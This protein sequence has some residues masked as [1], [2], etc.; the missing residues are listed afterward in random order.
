MN[1]ASHEKQLRE[2][3]S[4]WQPSLQRLCAAYES[5]AAAQEKLLKRMLTG[6][7]RSLPREGDKCSL[8]SWVYRIAFNVAA[9]R[10][11]RLVHKE[12]PPIAGSP[13]GDSESRLA[14]LHSAIRRM[15]PLN[16]QIIL[17]HLEEVPP[18][19][20]AEITGLA[21][22]DI[23]TRQRQ[24]EGRLV[25]LPGAD[26]TPIAELESAWKGQ[27]IDSIEISTHTLERNVARAISRVAFRDIREWAPALVLT[28]FFVWQAILMQMPFQ[29]AANVVLAVACVYVSYRL[30]RN[31]R[32]RRRGDETMTTHAYV[33]AH[34]AAILGQAHFLSRSR[35]WHLL[36]FLIGGGMLTVGILLELTSI[37]AP[38]EVLV[39]VAIVGLAA[40]GL[41]W[42]VDWFHVRSVR[43]LRERAARLD[44]VELPA[45]APTAGLAS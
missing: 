7:W 30:Y 44:D 43:K 24:V 14:A 16:R 12:P 22:R 11:A 42:L 45:P 37:G 33:D 4:Q 6:V 5:S 36:P 32:A 13:G 15:K 41:L 35:M 38:R 25:K 34:R 17:L 10:A 28:P 19:E 18:E 39:I 23:S 20:I 9:R 2:I 40:M 26:P 27:R 1:H 3:T 29:R 21:L 31:G 8:R